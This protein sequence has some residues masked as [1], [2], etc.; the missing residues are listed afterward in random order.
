MTQPVVVRTPTE[1]RRSLDGAGTVA[2]VPTMGALHEGHAQLLKHAAP[3]ADLLVASIFVNPT[4]FAPGEDFADYPRTMDVDPFSG[5]PDGCRE[6][7][8]SRAT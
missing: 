8:Q 7:P 1:L 4:Q 5:C 2:F 3:L 6:I